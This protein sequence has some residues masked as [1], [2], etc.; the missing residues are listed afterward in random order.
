MGENEHPWDDWLEELYDCAF[1][2]RLPGSNESDLDAE[3]LGK[4]FSITKLDRLIDNVLN[5]FY[6]FDTD[7]YLFD[8]H[9]D[10]VDR[11]NQEA[12]YEA[13]DEFHSDS[14]YYDPDS[15]RYTKKEADAVINLLRWAKKIVLAYNMIGM[16]INMRHATWW[17]KPFDDQIRLLELEAKIKSAMDHYNENVQGHLDGNLYREQEAMKQ[18]RKAA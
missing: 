16:E 5:K 9:F 15:L 10:Y 13:W 14:Y 1:K 2:V 17:K 18:S 3:I 12:L 7:T 6:D 8:Y 11:N 4:N